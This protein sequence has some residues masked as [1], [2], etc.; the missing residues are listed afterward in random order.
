MIGR[1]RQINIAQD[2]AEERILYPAMTSKPRCM[3]ADSMN[4]NQK[5]LLLV[6]LAL[7]WLSILIAP[8]GISFN[9]GNASGTVFEGYSL[10]WSMYHGI[11]LKHLLVEWAG[12]L[13][14][15]IGLFFYYKD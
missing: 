12:L 7:F 2:M 10:I 5:R 8:E 6:A 4:K 9:N 14:S 15:F 1:K 11:S 13:V 3:T